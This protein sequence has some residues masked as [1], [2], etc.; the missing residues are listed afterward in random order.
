M[1]TVEVVTTGRT[2]SMNGEIP[3]QTDIALGIITVIA[4]S[5][6]LELNKISIKIAAPPLH[7]ATEKCKFE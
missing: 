3:F 2:Y 7:S 4:L 5:V 6:F 1:R